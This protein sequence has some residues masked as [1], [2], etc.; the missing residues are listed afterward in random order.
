[1]T[2]ID[3]GIDGLDGTWPDVPAWFS[4]SS[5][6]DAEACPR[7]WAL[8]RGT[9]PRVWD[10]D[11]YPEGLNLASTRGDI[12]HEV[13]RTVTKAL[14]DAGC[15]DLS[16]ERAVGVMRELGGFS[17]LVREHIDRALEVASRNPRVAGRLDWLRQQLTFAVPEMRA[18]SQFLLGQINL[19]L[20][21]RARHEIGEPT[22]SGMN[23]HLADG[24]YAE[25]PVR[26]SALMFGGRFD[27]LTVS[28]KD[29]CILDYKTGAPK[30]NHVAQL[31]TYAALWA[32]RDGLEGPPLRAT[33]LCLTYPN[34]TIDVPP[35]NDQ[36][37]AKLSDDLIRRVVD[38]RSDLE[39]LPPPARPS[40]ET[41]QFCSVRHMCDPYWA[42]S[43]TS[44]EESDFSDVE[45][46]LG[47]RNGPRSWNVTTSKGSG[48]LRSRDELDLPS[49]RTIRVLGVARRDDDNNGSKIW[50]LTAWSEI[51]TTR[52]RN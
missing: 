22:T 4:F 13:L 51:Y 14:V 20:A 42:G 6:H 10:R 7:R 25:I 9:Y 47:E 34:Q 48:L 30:D 17:E 46:R 24:A 45:F 1:M 2:E 32:S 31:K 44:G 12:V 35:P 23:D 52:P 50:E 3:T 18:I 27:L 40:H 43:T 36:E 38:A 37:L 16:D 39:A 8:E 15:D 5:L 49:G 41:C 29:V 21:P 19:A 28:G 33:R 11:G 26:S